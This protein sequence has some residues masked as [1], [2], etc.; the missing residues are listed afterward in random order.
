MQDWAERIDKFLLADDCSILKNAGSI[1]A[2]IAK[3]HAG[4]EYE[5]YRITQDRLYKSDF[6]VFMELEAEYF[7]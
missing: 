1:T 5:V 3:D 6:D 7:R 4:S 2:E